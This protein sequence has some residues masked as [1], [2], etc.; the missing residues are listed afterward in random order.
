MRLHLNTSKTGVV[1][2]AV[3]ITF[4]GS[5]SAQIFGTQAYAAGETEIKV[6]A[7]AGKPVDVFEFRDPE[8][9]ELIRFQYQP[10]PISELRK[11]KPSQMRKIQ[12]QGI[13][14]KGTA[15]GAV[16][17]IAMDFPAEYA[18]FTLA[19]AFSTQIHASNTPTYARDFVEQNASAAGIASFA[20]FI[21][22]SRASH[23]VLQAYGLAYDPRRA[24]L[25]YRVQTPFRPGQVVPV[26]VINADGTRGFRSFEI[27]GRNAWEDSRVIAQPQPPTRF[28]RNFAPLLGPIGLSAGMVVSS[29]MHELM[30][31][32]N[33]RICAKGT[34]SPG[35]TSEKDKADAQAKVDAACDQ[36]WE[37]FAL[38]KKAADYTPD[39][40]AMASAS[41]IDAYFFK[42]GIIGGTKWATKKSFGKAIQKSGVVLGQ[43][44][45]TGGLEAR[46]VRAGSEKY[47]PWVLRGL[48]VGNYIG[49]IGTGPVGKFAMTV[50]NIFVF[51]EIVHPITPLI[52]KPF[53]RSRQGNDITKRIGDVL[54]EIDRA[55]KNKWSWSPRP[56]ADFCNLSTMY[57]TDAQGSPTPYSTC[58]VPEQPS[59]DFLLK[60]MAE[61]QAKWREFVLQDAY[62]S[63]T[64]WQN[65]VA[66]FATMYA[67]A[68]AFYEQIVSHINYQ[69]FDPRAKKD[70]SYLF[71]AD[72][73]AGLYTDPESRDSA[74]GQAA[75]AQAR[76]WL[77]TYLEGQRL[78][79][80]TSGF[81]TRSTERDS[82]PKILAGLQAVDPKVSLKSLGA[83]ESRVLDVSRMTAA[84]KAEFE[85]RVRQR[86]LSEGIT[87][88][89]RVLKHDS[90]YTDANVAFRSP[91]YERMAQT[92]P[93]M[94]LRL[95]LGDPRPMGIGHSFI[96]AAN[97]DG[98]V[99]GQDSKTNHPS[100][101]GRA[102]A[103][104][105][106]EYLML[107]MVCG[108]EIDPRFSPGQ[109]VK[110]YRERSLSTFERILD[111]FGLGGKTA[112]AN[113][114]NVLV[115]VKD[116]IEESTGGD[117][118]GLIPKFKE[119]AIVT[120]WAGY[121]AEFRP[122][123]LV[124]GIS[125]EICRNFAD[126]SNRDGSMFDP[127]EAKWTIGGVQY[128]GIIDIVTKKARAA[129]VGSELPPEKV[130]ENWKSPFEI[131]WSEKVDKHVIDTVA[132]FR[133]DYRL[134]LKEKYI[135][136]LTKTGVD[137]A[138]T[139]NGRS[140]K[141]GAF[142]ALYDEATLYM[143][144]LGKTSKVT[145]SAATRKAFDTL[146]TS[147][148]LEFK[149]V[150]GIIAD[151]DFV[152]QKGVIASAAYELKRKELEARLGE[153]ETFVKAREEKTKA[154]P[155]AVKINQQAMKNMTGLLGEM[156]SY[157]GV[158]RGIQVEG[159]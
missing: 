37:D 60:K 64:S 23:A 132:Q 141:L 155:D 10:T 150:A 26:G 22:A 56:D 88:L 139:Y 154:T 86:L 114:E 100:G 6:D 153:L 2:F 77:E 45:V 126:N 62:L 1:S 152:E 72:P 143:L 54:Y 149:N 103:N 18:A 31:D 115:A 128:D 70:V 4:I 34:Y 121:Q 80:R 131:W 97:D 148:L 11:I 84:Q 59:P 61:R 17:N 75:V 102:S 151:L 135:P 109:K 83:P 106:T 46:A 133:A 137:G 157:W 136:A 15:M 108:P 63:H 32:P 47:I 68:S 96:A 134:I 159:L 35:K 52:K 50:G 51:M 30:A 123:R 28:Q 120:E 8:T 43:S 140:F 93:F 38:T 127:F 129:V 116:H 55:E 124:E 40:L 113:D 48:R 25:D 79:A 19:M 57:E 33:L 144:I 105:M 53:E 87:E 78:K 130:D 110:I 20:G 98:S 85:T 145:E 39:V 95:R 125:P 118:S 73:F 138:K 36:F 7:S 147:V 142:E 12:T 76:A 146:T 69:R 112:S 71:Q 27:P 67:N 3:A 9:K 101:I 29:A 5:L 156:D 21:G 58:F 104:S 92:N 82:L 42:K 16:K 94:A 49:S 158:V 89:R 24:G 119:G 81:Q 91:M 14:P 65:Y 44:V 74:T 66:K 90:V 117:K 99:I 111:M 41:L 107:S 122:P 13:P